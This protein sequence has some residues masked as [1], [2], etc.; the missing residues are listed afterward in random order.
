MPRGSLGAGMAERPLL[1]ALWGPATVV[2]AFVAAG[3]VAFVAF[4]FY[5]L[6]VAEPFLQ[7]VAYPAAALLTGLGAALAAAWAATLLAP[8][9]TR[10]D[11]RRTLLWAEAAALAGLVLFLALDATGATPSKAASMAPL[12]VLAAGG[13]AFGALRARAPREGLKREAWRSVGLLALLL[14]GLYGVIG[15]ACAVGQCGA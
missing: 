14:V 10:T 11:L 5:G 2:A 3:L 8:D 13:A 9:R 1:K 12:V 15:V 6:V 7:L 4:A